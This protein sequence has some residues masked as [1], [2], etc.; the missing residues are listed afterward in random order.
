LHPAA[1]QRLADFLI[2]MMRSGRQLI[3]ETHSDHLVARLRRRIAEDDRDALQDEIGFLYVTRNP[4]TAST[5]YQAVG[6][7]IFG[8]LEDWPH[9]FFN[10]G[11]REAAEMIRQ[12]LE[13]KRQ[14]E[15]GS[16]PES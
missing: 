1:Q 8:G 4:A 2:A 10:Q 7:N 6:A 14:R 5:E 16:P 15:S 13:K 12:A 9:G 3:I 11:P